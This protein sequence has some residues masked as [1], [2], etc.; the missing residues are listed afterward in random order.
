MINKA[1]NATYLEMTLT[2]EGIKGSKKIKRGEDDVDKAIDLA[3][4]SR[5]DTSGQK[6]RTRL[7][8]ET[9]L[10]IRYLCNAILVPSLNLLRQLDKSVI[11]LLLRVLLKRRERGMT[12]RGLQ[13]M[14]ALLSIIPVTWR[15]I[16]DAINFLTNM[17]KMR[18]QDIP[19]R[20][21]AAA[22]LRNY[23]KRSLWLANS[24]YSPAT[25]KAVIIG[26]VTETDIKQ[27]VTKE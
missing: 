9:Y 14:V 3:K 25:L 19:L 4:T 18:N 8:L 7:L 13:M 2:G 10:E 16:S 6:N 21:K 1:L 24:V 15:T 20:N 5:L 23:A 12:E 17:E 26:K 22:K 11:K 27:A